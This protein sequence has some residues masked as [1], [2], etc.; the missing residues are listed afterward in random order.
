[1]ALPQRTKK[2]L[3]KK[4]ARYELLTHKTVYTAYDAAQTLKKELREIAKSL[5]IATDKAY[6]IAVIPADMRLDLTKLKKALN[7]KKISIPTEKIIIK[8]LKFKPGSL[9]AFGGLH[10]LETWVDKSLMKTKDVI[11]AAGSFTDSVRMK[12]K[13]FIDLE[14]A[15]LASFAKS[16]GY[17]PSKMTAK[18]KKKVRP[19]KKGST[20]KTGKRPAAKKKTTKRRATKKSR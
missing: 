18:K 6:I 3:D 7:A 10:Q 11:L 2:Y 20:K 5:L 8:Q 17:K 13:D 4:M 16:G 12:A 1:M 19:T 14:Q 9:T 15:R